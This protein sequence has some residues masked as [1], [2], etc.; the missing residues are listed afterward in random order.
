MC[1]TALKFLQEIDVK[2]LMRN[3]TE[4]NLLRPILIKEDI[5]LGKSIEF[6]VFHRNLVIRFFAIFKKKEKKLISLNGYLNKE[7]YLQ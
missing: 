4:Q 2:L 3:F 6:L 7:K 1:N 5:E